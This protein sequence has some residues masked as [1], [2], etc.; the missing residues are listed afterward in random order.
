[1]AKK[2]A[3]PETCEKCPHRY[4][5]AGCPCWIGPQAGFMETNVV[6]K[7]ERF[8]TGCFYQVIP[9]LMV[10]VIKASN[11]PAAAVEGIRNEMV[12]GMTMIAQGLPVLRARHD[13][14]RHDAIAGPAGAAP[15][16]IEHSKAQPG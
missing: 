5:A 6:T 3:N 14:P 15:A 9:K 2:T 4:D 10:E 8:V 11:R 1:M 13:E 16:M 7:E 12:R